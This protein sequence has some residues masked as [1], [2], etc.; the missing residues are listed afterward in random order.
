[1]RFYTTPHQL[2]CG[3]DL[4]AR[5]MYVCILN[6]DGEIML[7]R[8]MKASPETFLK[9]IA[10]HREEMVVAVECIF[11]W[12]WL[13]DL[14]AQEGIP[15]I[16]GHA[17]YMEAIHGGKAK[18]DTIDAHK[19]AVLLR[20]G[21]LPQAYV[22]P[23]AMRATR[24]LLRRRMYLTRKRAERLA[25]IQN[26]NSPYNLPE[27]GKKLAYKANRDGVAERFPDP[28]VQKSMEVDMA[29]L[30]YYDPRLNELAL[31]S[32]KA[33][34]QPD[35][36]TLSLLQTVPGI[37]KILS[38]VL[39]YEI[40]DIQRFPSVPDF[41]SG[42]R[43]VQCA[44]ELAGKRYGTAGTKMGHAYLTWAFSAA[45]GLF[46]RDHPAGQKYLTRLAKKHGQ[47]KAL[48]LLTQKLGRAVDHMVKRQQAFAMPK[49]R[50]E[51]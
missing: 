5:T 28:A 8:N 4:H 29:L 38:L 25:H 44:K 13:A 21:M 18:H 19:I 6:Q 20:G 23:A 27:M 32:L 17:L 2:Y 34:T 3:I 45:A 7:H 24:D 41:V 50:S 42:G 33:A 40:H 10:P 30:E 22:Y 46:L 14:C 37:G 35:A 49:F 39:L 1:M 26:T 48:T 15:C 11:T 16:L 43:L 12:S 36:N 9:A 31:H 51:S 47:G